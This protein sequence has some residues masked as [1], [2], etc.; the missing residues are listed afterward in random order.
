MDKLL[1]FALGVFLL[2]VAL[3]AINRAITGA[4]EKRPD[5]DADGEPDETPGE[6]ARALEDFDGR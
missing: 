2:M 6:K 5:L 3:A 4:N 1:L